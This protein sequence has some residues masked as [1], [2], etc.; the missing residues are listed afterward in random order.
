MLDGWHWRSAYWN[1]EELAFRGRNFQLFS[2]FLGCLFLDQRGGVIKKTGGIKVEETFDGRIGL[3]REIEQGEV[4]GNKIIW[5]L[6]KI[7]VHY[8]L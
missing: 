6:I 1:W 4:R 2:H 3:A 8:K 7:T 5:L